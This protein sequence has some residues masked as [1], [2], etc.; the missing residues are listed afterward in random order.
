MKTIVLYTSRYGSTQKYAQWMAQALGCEAKKAGS[1]TDLSGYD[2][3]LYGG[4]LYAGGVAGFKKFLKKLDPAKPGP[5]ILLF[6]VGMTSPENTEFY[7]GVAERSIPEAW[8]GRIYPFA[9]RGDIYF[10]RMSF[11]HKSVMRM[12]RAAA[13]KKPAEER[14]EQEQLFVELCNKDILFAKEENIAPLLKQIN[15]WETGV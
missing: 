15:E 1:V 11:L 13:A 4:G 12:L 6:M 10:S 8:K 5:R 2:L 3:V 7:N 14:T 9:L